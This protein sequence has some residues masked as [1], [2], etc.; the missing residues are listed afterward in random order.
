MP[1]TGTLKTWVLAPVLSLKNCL[2]LGRSLNLSKTQFYHIR[3]EHYYLP[4]MVIMEVNCVECSKWSAK[5]I[6]CIIGFYTVN[7]QWSSIAQLKLKQ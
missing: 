7:G 5:Q 3:Q 4:G 2:F 1:L 6:L